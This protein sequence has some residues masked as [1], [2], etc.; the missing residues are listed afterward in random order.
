MRLSAILNPVRLTLFP[1]Y[2]NLYF[3]DISIFVTRLRMDIKKLI[4]EYIL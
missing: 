1:F 2:S 3:I 4:K